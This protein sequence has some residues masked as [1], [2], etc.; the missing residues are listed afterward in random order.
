[1]HSPPP[2]ATPATAIS[3][4]YDAASSSPTRSPRTLDPMNRDLPP[5]RV[6]PSIHPVLGS[7]GGRKRDVAGGRGVESLSPIRCSRTVVRG[8]TRLIRAQKCTPIAQLGQAR[9]AP[10]QDDVVLDATDPLGGM[11]C[12]GRRGRVAGGGSRQSCRRCLHSQGAGAVVT[13]SGPPLD[14]AI[15]PWGDIQTRTRAVV[16]VGS[17]RHA[18]ATNNEEGGDSVG[19]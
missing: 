14:P 12:E 2:D 15:R 13:T 11:R 9:D 4:R 7:P 16:E 5:P 1:M 3:S 10:R 19:S 17:A 8:E 6:D 18:P